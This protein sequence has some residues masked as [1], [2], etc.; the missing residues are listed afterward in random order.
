MICKAA[1]FSG[2]VQGV[3]FRYSTVQIAERFV[4]AGT[5]KNL[6]D[7]RVELVVQGERAEVE[8]LIDAVGE[9]M[10]RYIRQTQVDEREPA[11]SLGSPEAGGVRVAY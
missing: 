10:S 11:E 7:G 2:H 4:V 8:G 5:V 9:R 3:G 6:S 1:Y